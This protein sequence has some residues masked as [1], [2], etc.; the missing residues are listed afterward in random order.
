MAE[1]TRG[2]GR[3]SEYDPSHCDQVVELGKMGKSKA[4]IAAALGVSR[5]TLHNW[6]AAHPEFL[7]AV[8]S[9][10]DLALAWW[11]DRGQESLTA[12][13]FNATAFIFQMKNRFS[14]D[15]R[16]KQEREHS[17]ANGGPIR[18]EFDLS[19]LSMEELDALEAIQ[20]KLLGASAEVA[21]E[22]EETE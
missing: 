10:H 12:D 7:D 6:A 14:E 21:A 15:Y 20:R 18:H 19:G 16:D 13:K 22:P 3:P 5:Q 4:Q 11:E 8:K 9:A 2:P 1:E 17:G